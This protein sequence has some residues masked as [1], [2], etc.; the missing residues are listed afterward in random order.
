MPTSS[1]R[2]SL[3]IAV[4]D[5]ASR[6][7][8]N[9]IKRF[10]TLRKEITRV[11]TAFGKTV[12]ATTKLTT[13]VNKMSTGAKRA[14][15]A[16]TKMRKEA[17]S[18]SSAFNTTAKS[19]QGAG[20]AFSGLGGSI[21]SIAAGGGLLA[22]AK[23]AVTAAAEFETLRKGF[24]SLLGSAEAADQ[25]IAQM[26]LAAQDP[27]LTFDLVAQGVRRFKAFGVEVNKGIGYM[28]ALGN[29]GTLAGQGLD[30]I[31]EGAR[32]ISKVIATQKLEADQYTTI[33]ETFGEVGKQI[34]ETYGNSA[35]E[36]TKRLKQLGL[37]FNDFFDDVLQLD[38]QTKASA[39]TTLNAVSNLQNAWKEL[40]VELGNTLLPAV[41]KVIERLTDLVKWVNSL[42]DTQKEVLAWSTA[43]GGAFLVLAGP[44]G[45]VVKGIKA[46]VIA[47]GTIKVAALAIVAPIAKVVAIIGGLAG[48]I[49]GTINAIKEYIRFADG[50]AGG[51]GKIEVIG[52]VTDKASESTQN[53]G[54]AIQVTAGEMDSIAG[55]ADKPLLALTR[56]PLLRRIWA[57]QPLKPQIRLIPLAIQWMELPNL[58]EG[59]SKRLPQKAV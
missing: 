27:G 8:D 30:R 52:E 7:L 42:T 4:T 17:Q 12:T 41:N 16:M 32:Q 37:T 25:A 44:I 15:T 43:V 38:K 56:Q 57:T 9:A 18:A 10:T 28:R 53:L 29:A 2:V 59:C 45:T 36:V 46:L 50:I 1:N 48:A 49:W 14:Q 39:D 11:Q 6:V 22:L 13:N 31:N 40:Q 5:N 20:Q 47:W 33:L 26:R 21:A 55:S 34:R 51:A 23:G 35:E 54:M 58:P 24:I 3:E 19:A